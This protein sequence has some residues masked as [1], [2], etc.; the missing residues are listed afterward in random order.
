MSKAVLRVSMSLTSA[1][2]VLELCCTRSGLDPARSGRPLQ[3]TRQQTP[4]VDNLSW[5]LSHLSWHTI[6]HLPGYSAV[7]FAITCLQDVYRAVFRA[8]ATAATGRFKP[9]T[10]VT[11]ARLVWELPLDGLQQ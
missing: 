9:T 7:V 6:D 10:T 2:L 4:A 3:Y 11:S 1:R 5:S 8:A